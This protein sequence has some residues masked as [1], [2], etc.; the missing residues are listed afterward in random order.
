MPAS[1]PAPPSGRY[2]DESNLARSYTAVILIEIVVLA[3]LYWLGRH[4]G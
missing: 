2:P 4:F 1:E 3:A